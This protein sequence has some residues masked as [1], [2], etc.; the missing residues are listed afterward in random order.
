MHRTVSHSGKQMYS[1]PPLEILP[2]RF[3]LSRVYTVSCAEGGE[4]PLDAGIGGG[5]HKGDEDSRSYRVS[6]VF[7]SIDT[8]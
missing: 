7:F 6:G 1:F 3:S 8:L 2:A 4:S 5:Q